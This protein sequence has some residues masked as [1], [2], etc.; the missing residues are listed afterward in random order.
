MCALLLPCAVAWSVRNVP[1][2]L[3]VPG[4]CGVAQLLQDEQN[5]PAVC[6]RKR[7]PS[8]SQLQISHLL[9]RGEVETRV[10]CSQW[11]A[12]CSY[13]LKIKQELDTS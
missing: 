1:S 3:C 7:R 13:E 8:S 12:H 11:V 9:R 4:V 6:C 5:L 2:S 10:C